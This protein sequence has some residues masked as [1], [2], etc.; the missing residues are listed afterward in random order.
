MITMVCTPGNWES[1]G[2][3]PAESALPASLELTNWGAILYTAH[4]E[5]P[6]RRIMTRSHYL[7]EGEEEALRLDLKTDPRM[8]EEQARWA[9][10][11]PGMRV[12]DLGCGSGK[13]AFH[14]NRL[15]SPG[16]QTVGVDISS[17]RIEFAR[18]HYRADGLL[19]ECRDIRQ[20][21]HDLG[22]FDF[23]WLRFVLEYYRSS[24]F[25]IVQKIA[26]NLAP[27]GIL[28]LIDLDHNCL[29]HYGLSDRMQATIAGILQTL[30]QTADFDPYAGRKLYSHLYDL[31]FTEIRVTLMP[32]HLIYGALKPSDAF[33]WQKKLEV[34][35][36]NAGYVFDAYP[37]GYA[38]FRREFRQFFADPRRFTYTPAIVCCGRKP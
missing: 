9:G 16:G 19:F 3:P 6:R 8:V 12:A 24:S 32:H 4:I 2:W 36:Q 1:N 30:E 35:A 21:L 37:D 17:Q 13:T 11:N 28:C 22:R 29:N 33:N 31:E 27:G 26:Q 10:I 5:N 25:D 34:A 18:S 15:V 38:G 7:M 20:P 23:L 14:L